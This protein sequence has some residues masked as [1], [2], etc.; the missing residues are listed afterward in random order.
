MVGI[1][2][3]K[4]LQIYILLTYHFL[5]LHLIEHAV[6][7]PANKN[8][9]YHF[10]WH[11]TRPWYEPRLNNGQAELYYIIKSGQV[12]YILKSIITIIHYTDPL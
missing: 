3:N 6:F 7:S 12:R 8:S 4:F 9:M 10:A 1:F 5:E 11:I 2:V